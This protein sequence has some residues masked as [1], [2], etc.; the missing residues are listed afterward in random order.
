LSILPPEIGALE[1]IGPKQVFR[2]DNN[3]WVQSIAEH[4]QLGGPAAVMDH[5]RSETYK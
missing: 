3:P 1:L 4:L 2:L 5:I